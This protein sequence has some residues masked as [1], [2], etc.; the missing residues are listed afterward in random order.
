MRSRNNGE[1]RI[2]LLLR[3]ILIRRKLTARAGLSR[4]TPP[5]CILLEGIAWLLSERTL[6]LAVYL[7]S[8]RSDLRSAND[9]RLVRTAQQNVRPVSRGVIDELPLIVRLLLVVNADGR[10]LA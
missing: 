3:L 4:S 8:R 9:D 1:S 10:I 2:I 7:P 6:L 5:G